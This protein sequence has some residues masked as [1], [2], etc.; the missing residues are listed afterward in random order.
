MINGVAQKLEYSQVRPEGFL[1]GGERR[2]RGVWWGMGPPAGGRPSA[3]A[4]LPPPAPSFVHVC[5]ISIRRN[6]HFV[7]D[8]GKSGSKGL[9]GRVAQ[10]GR[11]PT[12][13]LYA[14]KDSSGQ[15]RGQR[16]GGYLP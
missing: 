7:V 16:W 3:G 9:I 14:K 15:G 12:H 8:G 6:A 1:I 11:A 10:R 4:A 2:G 5:S 13:M